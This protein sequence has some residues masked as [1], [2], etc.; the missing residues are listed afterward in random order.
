LVR[1]D[2]S[3][4]EYADN[5]ADAIYQLEDVAASISS[6]EADIDDNPRRLANIEERLNLI[7]KLRRKYGSSI[8]EILQRADDDRTELDGITNRDEI[9]AKLQQQDAQFRQEI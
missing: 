6:Y 1:L 4:E 9:I 8:E 5:L 7:A 2:Q 3:M